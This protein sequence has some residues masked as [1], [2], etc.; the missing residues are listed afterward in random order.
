MSDAYLF[1]QISN[2]VERIGKSGGS[3][4]LSYMGSDFVSPSRVQKMA[5]S[6]VGRCRAVIRG[7]ISRYIC[8]YWG[9]SLIEID[10]RESDWWW[11][12][13]MYILPDEQYMDLPE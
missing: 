6:H 1:D 3:R 7:Y 10:R 9:A 13:K 8:V 5:A 4:T 12:V 2:R 11:R